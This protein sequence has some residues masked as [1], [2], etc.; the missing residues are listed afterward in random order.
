[1]SN[2]LKRTFTG[3]VFLVVM[4]GGIAW[5]QYSF[6]ALFFLIAI[7]GLD[8]FYKLLIKSGHEP[9][10]KL[11]LLCGATI[12]LLIAIS[13]LIDEQ[14]V[15]YLS[16]VLLSTIFFAELYRNKQN[17]FQNIA[18]SILGIV[19]IVMPFALWV[20]FIK[21]YSFENGGIYNPH[22]LLGF[23]FLLWTNDTGAY[24]VGISIG[25]HKLW[26]RI[27]PK[28][29]W[30]G[31]FGGLILSMAI[32]YGI[33]LFYTEL[34]YI[35]WMLMAA[36]VSIFGTMGDLVESAFKRSLDVKDSGSILPGHGGI[37]DRF[38]GVFLS[39]PFVLVLLQLVMTLNA[40]LE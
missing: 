20:N 2:F 39:T 12:F 7:L 10:R 22:L 32:G 14:A 28:K 35:L 19:Y 27:S 1:V 38:D 8:E 34:H 4:I 37:L 9:Q 13:K 16:F 29:T 23:F 6:Y 17:P 11:G 40:I 26:E 33:S 21:G 5:N 18:Y 30:E 24:L 3:A 25:K 36:I 31:F 15:V